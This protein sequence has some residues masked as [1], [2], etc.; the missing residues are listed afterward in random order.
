MEVTR[1]SQQRV[2]VAT[3]RALGGDWW[4]IGEFTT[5]LGSHTAKFGGQIGAPLFKGVN[6]SDI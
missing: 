4:V 6:S 2:R 3:I 5:N 1:G